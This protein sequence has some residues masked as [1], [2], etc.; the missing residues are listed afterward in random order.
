VES[1]ILIVG[2]SSWIGEK[3]EGSRRKSYLYFM[4]QKRFPFFPNISGK[5]TEKHQVIRLERFASE[6]HARFF[7]GA[8][9]F[10]GIA[11]LAGSYQI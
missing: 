1:S 3:N 11:A 8:V 4:P 2:A 10:M 6:R 5:I 9:S 7:R